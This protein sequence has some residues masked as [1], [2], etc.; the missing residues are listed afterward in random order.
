ML[1]ETELSAPLPPLLAVLSSSPPQPS[2][3]AA[4]T[5]VA[6]SAAAR[7]QASPGRSALQERW[8]C[9]FVFGHTSSGLVVTFTNVIDVRYTTGKG[10]HEGYRGRST[11]SRGARAD[12]LAGGGVLLEAV[13]AP[14]RLRVRVGVLVDSVDA[15]EASVEGDDRLP[16]VAILG[17]H[18]DADDVASGTGVEH[19]DHV[20]QGPAGRVSICA[21][22][23]GSAG[24]SS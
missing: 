15:E 9:G 23:A 10:G 7:K 2:S 21:K 5:P 20:E 19:R 1:V 12:D 18:R 13:A 11:A 24:S 3:A 17:G 22:P 8:G 6:P 14:D 16:L 4:E